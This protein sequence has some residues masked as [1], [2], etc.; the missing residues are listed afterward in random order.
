MTRIRIFVLAGLTVGLLT[1]AVCRSLPRSGFATPAACL[2]GYREAC[3]AGDLERYERC[4][5]EPLRS[6]MRQ[7]HPDPQEF[8]EFLRRES[9]GI[10][11]WVQRLDG[12]S[13]GS[14]V[15]I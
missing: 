5:A 13:P 6:E 1:L 4:L 12:A 7:R 9:K 11:S 14:S 10:K 3:L 8:A 2:E 15:G